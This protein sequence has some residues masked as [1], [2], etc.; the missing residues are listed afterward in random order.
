MVD[1]AKSA[2]ASKKLD[3]GGVHE[4][5]RLRQVHSPGAAVSRHQLIEHHNIKTSRCAENQTNRVHEEAQLRRGLPAATTLAARALAID[6]AR[7]KTTAV[8]QD[9]YFDHR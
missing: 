9:A 2:A 3:G 5:R 7:G 8:L 6:T 4:V 1:T